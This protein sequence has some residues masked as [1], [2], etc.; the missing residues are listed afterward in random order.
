MLYVPCDSGFALRIWI[1]LPDYP[2]KE[3]KQVFKLK[4]LLIIMIKKKNKNSDLIKNSNKIMIIEVMSY[5][6]I[7]AQN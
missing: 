5:L 1:L 6:W 7:C 4:K 3:S 2:L